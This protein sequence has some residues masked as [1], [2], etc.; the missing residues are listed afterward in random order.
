MIMRTSALFVL[1]ALVGCGG[2]G[3][4]VDA[5]I[6]VDAAAL[7]CDNYCAL[8]QAGCTGPNA[9]YTGVDSAATQQSCTHTCVLFAS[10]ISADETS[11]NTLGCRLHYAV[12]ASDMAAAA[13]AVCA[14]AGPVGDVMSPSP[15]VCSGNDACTT[16]CALEIKACGSQDLPLPG[17]PTDESNASIFQYRNMASCMS[18]CSGSDGKPAF[19]KDH[20]SGPAARGYSLACRLYQATQ[21][22]ISVMPDAVMFC[23]DTSRTPTG[24]CAGPATS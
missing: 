1:G 6:P 16:F 11:G 24:R 21:A 20:A 12:E 23:A 17:D 5:A 2:N 22:V 14:Q 8:I 19:D 4:A 3:H 7:T 10:G 18:A 9:Q 13:P 15:A